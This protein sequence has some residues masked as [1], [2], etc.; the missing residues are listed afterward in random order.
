MAA[1]DLF[2]SIKPGHDA[3][4]RSAAAVT[5]SDGTDMSFVTR[6]LYIGTAGDV[7]VIMADTGTAIL[8][9]AVPAG[10]VLP[11]MVSRVKSTGTTASDIVALY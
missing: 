5:P 2:G 1:T 9:K 8:F 6:G 11:I 7:T 3:P 10:T 4:A